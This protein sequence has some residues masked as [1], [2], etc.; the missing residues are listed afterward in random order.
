MAELRAELARHR[1]TAA[2]VA[3]RLDRSEA[4]VSRRLT[5]EIPLNLDDLAE[6]AE[7]LGIA[8]AALIARAQVQDEPPAAANGRGSTSTQ[9]PSGRNGLQ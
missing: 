7:M 2:E 1:I 6:I 3:Q 8:P 9:A 4:Y 5:G